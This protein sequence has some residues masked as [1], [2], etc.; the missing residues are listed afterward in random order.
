[1]TKVQILGAVLLAAGVAAAV[2]LEVFGLVFTQ[3]GSSTT[4][5]ESPSFPVYVTEVYTSPNYPV[6]V[7]L[8]VVALVGLACLIAPTIRRTGR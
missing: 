1:M 2:A 8:A 5:V 4:Q 3:T 7:P 6:A